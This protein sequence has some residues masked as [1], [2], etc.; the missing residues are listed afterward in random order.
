YNKAHPDIALWRSLKN[1]LTGAEGQAYFE[2]NLK[3]ADVPGGAGVVKQFKGKVVSAAGKDVV[4]AVDN[5]AGDATLRFES[6]L[7]G[8]VE[9]GTDVEFDGVP[10]S[11]TKEPYMITFAVDKT[12]VKGLGAATAGGAARAPARRPAARKKR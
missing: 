6:A 1:E 3:G 10:E 7:R 11:F 9:V 8:K 2:K 4:V 5:A 12:K